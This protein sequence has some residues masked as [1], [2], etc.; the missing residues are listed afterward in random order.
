MPF[1]SCERFLSLYFPGIEP[2]ISN[3]FSYWTLYAEKCFCIFCPS[4]FR[5]YLNNICFI[6][7]G[8]CFLHAEKI[9]FLSLLLC[10]ECFF[11]VI[12][13]FVWLFYFDEHDV[14]IISSI[15]LRFLYESSSI[16]FHWT[17][18]SVKINFKQTASCHQ[19]YWCD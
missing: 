14:R 1:F 2:L 8:L 3:D 7:R 5:G 19:I 16:S 15:S 6:A 11:W 17:F 10:S 12:N 13:S 9:W 4:F 18:N